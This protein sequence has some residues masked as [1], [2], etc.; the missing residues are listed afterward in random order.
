M[1]NKKKATAIEVGVTFVSHDN[2][3]RIFEILKNIRN[4]FDW[5]DWTK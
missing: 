4:D 5:E 2:K 3:D 1:K